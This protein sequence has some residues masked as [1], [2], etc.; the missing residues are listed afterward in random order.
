MLPR[1]IYDCRGAKLLASSRQLANGERS[2][3]SRY[4]L[5]SFRRLQRR[6]YSKNI[7]VYIS[8][9]SIQS[10]LSFGRKENGKYS[11]SQTLSKP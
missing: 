7:F 4:V 11:L 2:L 1:R 3:K 9:T 10:T 6:Y 5:I 8:E